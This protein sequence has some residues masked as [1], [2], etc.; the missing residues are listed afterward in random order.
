MQPTE[1][2]IK[3]LQTYLRKTLNYKESYEEVYDHIISALAD[4]PDSGNFQDTVNDIIVQDFGGH[5]NLLQVE[6]G[7]GSAITTDTYV[8]FRTYLTKLLRLPALLYL[9]GIAIAFYVFYSSVNL[10]PLM[11]KASVLL[12]VFVPSM[13]ALFRFFHVGYV[14]GNKARSVRDLLFSNIAWLPVMAFGNITLIIPMAFENVD[15]IW[16]GNY[17]VLTTL[18]MLAAIVYNIAVF[19]LYREEVKILK[20]N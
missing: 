5:D 16:S 13:L 15:Q 10:P 4:R 18:C 9:A 14:T 11:L 6:Q 17:P 20:S 7:I 8:R 19:K 3:T 1:Q 12:V 2:Q